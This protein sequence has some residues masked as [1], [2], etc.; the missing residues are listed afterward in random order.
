MTTD[1]VRL[2]GRPHLAKRSRGSHSDRVPLAS[3]TSLTLPVSS[4]DIRLKLLH[5]GQRG[6]E[7]AAGAPR[8]SAS[9]PDRIVDCKAD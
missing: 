6:A 2:A 3:A 7:P 9:Q 5:N 1:E 8:H 4:Q